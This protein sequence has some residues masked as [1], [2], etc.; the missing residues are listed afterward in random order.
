MFIDVNISG[1]FARIYIEN[2]VL[3]CHG[4]PAEPGSVVEKSY[5]RLAR[6]FSKYFNPVIFDFPGCGL[7]RGEFRL[8]RWVE[9]FVT[10]ADSFSAVDIVAFS[11][12]GVP[13]VYAA[14]NLRHVRSLTLV[15]TPCCFEAIS[16][17]V[18][19]QIYSNAKS[20]GTLKGVRDFGTF[21][22]ELKEDMIEFEPLK[23]IENIRN[24]LFIHGTKDDVIPIESSERMFRLA[25]NPKKFLRVVG[26]GHK[27][28]QEKAVIDA[29]IQWIVEEKKKEGVE[30]L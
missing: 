6:Y 27:L 20:R 4:L 5:D 15:A 11:M 3:I 12:G 24:V 30:D 8:R 28:R 25:K 22:R 10:I 13:A 2:V 18:L 1:N 14:A 17:D 16:E 23:W 19:H 26:G 29:I 21:I 7:S 9:D